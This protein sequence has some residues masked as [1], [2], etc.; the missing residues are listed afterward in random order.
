M[1]KKIIII[2]FSVFLYATAQPK[3]VADIYLNFENASLDSVVNYLAKQKNINFIHHKDLKTKTVSLTTREPLT[4][5]RAWNVLLTL[6]EMNNF[7]IIDVNGVYRIVP[8]NTNKQEPLP[9]YSSG[10]GVEPEDLPESDLVVRYVYILKNISTQIAGKILNDLLGPGKVHTNQDLA[11]CII[12]DKCFN[13]KSAMKIVKELDTGGLRESIKIIRLRHTNA[14]EIANLFTLHIMERPQNN[15]QPIRFFGPKET[16]EIT[17]FSNTTKIIPEPRQNALILLGLEDNINRV[18]DF[19]HKYLDIPME[20]AQSRVHIKE[21]KYVEAIKMKPILDRMVKP[22]PEAA[23]K[24]PLVGEFKFFEDVVIHAENPK[25]GDESMGSGNRLIISCNQDDWRRLEILIN[26]LD[27]PQPQVAMEVMVVDID[28]ATERELGTQIREKTGKSLV[29]GMG[30]FTTNLRSIQIDPDSEQSGSQ[31]YNT[32]LGPVAS[33]ERG[34]TSITA[35]KQGDIWMVIKSFFSKTN[36]NI[37]TQPFMI[38]QNNTPAKQIVTLAKTI[39][40]KIEAQGGQRIQKYDTVKAETELK[41]TPRINLN[42]LVDLQVEIKLSEFLGT[43]AADRPNRSNRNIQT[44]TSMATGEVLVLGGL[45]K[46]K[47]TINLYKT[48]ILGSIPIL[49]NLFRS[50]TKSIDKTNLYVFVRPSI[51]KPKFEGGPDEYT[52]LKL[53][54]AKYQ[55]MNVEEIRKTRDPI[56]RWFFKPEKQS[57]KQKLA[58]LRKG[59]F[60]PID[61]YSEA[62]TQP[63][64]VRIER[65]P[66]FRAEELIEA[67]IRQKKLS[68]DIKKERLQRKKTTRR[69]KIV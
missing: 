27:K 52:Q 64:S 48:P 12:T 31:E 25:V 46:K 38:T 23:K 36:T 14:D 33:G 30:W 17:Y 53:D 45:T 13:I 9:F 29:R 62:K 34:T 40:G 24:S 4:L 54:Y 28:E 39:A 66:Y 16:K 55:I 56:Q 35:G 15:Q 68:E 26:K 10:K 3:E 59:M 8:S 37:I 47:T 49:G 60:R 41:I 43:G 22:P 69:K 1:S 7:T 21:L 32:D 57:I 58:D 19:I 63:K 51:I 5:E 2:L 6:L 44:R 67:E 61:E 20:A 65:D 42:G 18:I 50:K 11:T